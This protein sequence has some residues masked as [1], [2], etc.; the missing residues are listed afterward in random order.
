[1]ST[2]RTNAAR[3]LGFA[4]GTTVGSLI[5]ADQSWLFIAVMGMAVSA[6]RYAEG[7]VAKAKDLALEGLGMLLGASEDIDRALGLN[8]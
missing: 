4:P 7:D 3:S 6:V 2:S 1:M 8:P 5:V